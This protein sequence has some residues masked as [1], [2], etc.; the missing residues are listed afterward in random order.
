MVDFKVESI[1]D[2]INNKVTPEKWTCCICLKQ[3]SKKSSRN[4]HL[5]SISHNVAKH[6][7]IQEQEAKWYI[8]PNVV[9]YYCA[10]SS[11]S[12]GLLHSQITAQTTR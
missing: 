8:N 6:N 11:T 7:F 2:L 4:T 12:T 9:D 1:L 5:N 10:L 3:L